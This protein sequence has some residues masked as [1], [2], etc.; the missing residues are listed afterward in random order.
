MS[1]NKTEPVIRAGSG[2]K[3]AEIEGHVIPGKSLR[4]RWGIS[5]TQPPLG[6]APPATPAADTPP[7]AAPATQPAPK[8]TKRKPKPEIQPRAPTGQFVSPKEIAEI[9]QEVVSAAEKKKETPATVPQPE[10]QL[11]VQQ[12]KK[13]NVF[14]RMEALNPANKGLAEKYEASVKALS[15]YQTN[16]EKDA[17]NKGKKF[18]I[19]DDEHKDFLEQ[20]DVTY[21]DDEYIEA[22]ADM[23]SEEKTKPFEEKL[24]SQD[25]ERERAKRVSQMMPQIINHQRATAKVFLGQLGDDFKKLLDEAGV[26]VP[27]ERERIETESAAHRQVLGMAQQVET[28]AAEFMGVAQ[29]LVDFN[30]RNSLHVEMFHFIQRQEADTKKLPA[31]QQLNE[32]GKQFATSEEWAKMSDRER[33][34]YWH[35]SDT[36]LSALYASDMAD[37]AQQLLKNYEDDFN[38]LARRRGLIKDNP[39][40]QP[41]PVARPAPV[42]TPVQP[43]KSPVGQ[44]APRVA[45]TAEPQETGVA[46]LK[47]R[48]TS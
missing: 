8:P 15:D 7:A 24:K 41:V 42:R 46:A 36:D 20:H 32:E 44:I 35:L 38:N 27:A 43:E 26:V 21:D 39:N 17:A 2:D 18:N 47:K 33:K 30:A 16:W 25:Q 11:T 31:A 1:T 13:V 22:L 29:G 37:K 19:E 12:Q 48:W 4:E 40:P 14:K 3:P 34:G 28:M 23:R 45:P 6:A 9:A 5:D 10:S